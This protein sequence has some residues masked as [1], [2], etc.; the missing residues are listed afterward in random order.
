MSKVDGDVVCAHGSEIVFPPEPEDFESE[1]VA[2]VL[3]R[4]FDVFHGELRTNATRTHDPTFG[5]WCSI[6]PSLRLRSV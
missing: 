5:D 3:L 1:D 4:G 6:E 2:V